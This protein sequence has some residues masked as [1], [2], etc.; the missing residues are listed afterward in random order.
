MFGVLD[1]VL[2]KREWLVG[3]KCTIADLAF[4]HWNALGLELVHDVD[5]PARFPA[6]YA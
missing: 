6:M 1:S 2:A 3:G 5:V 4:L